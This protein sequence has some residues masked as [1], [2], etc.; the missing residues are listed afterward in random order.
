MDAL[1]RVLLLLFMK[2]QEIQEQIGKESYEET[3]QKVRD[4]LKGLGASLLAIKKYGQFLS[5]HRQDMR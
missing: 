3:E 2:E 5:S 4:V 1:G